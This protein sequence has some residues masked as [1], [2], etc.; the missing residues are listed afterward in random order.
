MIPVVVRSKTR[1]WQKRVSAIQSSFDGDIPYTEYIIDQFGYSHQAQRPKYFL[2]AISSYLTL[3]RKHR[4]RIR[5]R[6]VGSRIRWSIRTIRSP[7]PWLTDLLFSENC[8]N[9]K[10]NRS[11]NPVSYCRHDHSAPIFF[12]QHFWRFLFL[13]ISE[14]SIWDWFRGKHILEARRGASRTKMLEIGGVSVDHL[15][16]NNIETTGHNG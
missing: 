3:N 1:F 10:Q 9:P 5:A 2:A 14:I 6:H 4:A 8:W 11:Q 15:A 12:S 16:D 7:L 13:K